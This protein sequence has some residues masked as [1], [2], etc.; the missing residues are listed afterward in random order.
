M[1]HIQTSNRIEYLI[2]ALATVINSEPLPPLTKEI[3]VVQSKGMERWV[4]MG[5]AEQL[6]V[7][8]NGDFPFPNKIVWQFFKK[9]LKSLDLSE[10]S[11]FDPEVMTWSLMEILPYFL[12][13]QEF[14]ELGSYLQED[15][16]DIKR[17]QLAWRIAHIFDQYVIFRP[18]WIAAWEKGEQPSE[19]EKDSQAR[20]QAILWR[21]LIERYGIEHRAKLRAAFFNKLSRATNNLRF[22]KRF[23]VFGLSAL[24]PFHLEVLA[25][26]GKVIDVYIFLLNPCME[27]WGDI[28]SDSEIAHRTAKLKE[29]KSTPDAQYYERGNTLLASMGKM[30][31]D[32]I[33][34]LNEYQHDSQDYF[35]DL[36]ETTL[37]NCIQSDILH[38][39]E[40]SEENATLI[41]PFDKSIQIHACHSPM[42]EIEV[43]HDQLLALFEEDTTLLPKDIVVMMPDI[44][45]YAP[46]IEAVFATTPEESKKIPY[47][48]ADR[49][50]RGESAV[51]DTFFAIL[52]LSH[53][54]FEVSQVL[55][56]LET[57]A[58]QKCFK[59]SEQDFDLI[60]H[61]IEK[62]GI[63]WG[64]DKTDRERMNLPAYD[65]NTWRAGLKRLLLGYTLPGNGEHLFNDILPYDEIEGSDTLILG[66]LVS[67]VEKLFEYVQALAQPRTLPEWSEFLKKMLEDFLESGDENNNAQEIRNVLNKLVEN[68]QQVGFEAPVS[69]EVILECLRHPLT[70][71]KEQKI[72]FLTGKVTFCAMLPMRSI[73]FKVVCLLGM[74]DQAYPRPSK[75]LG[76]DLLAKNPKPGDRSRRQND[77]Y[78]F[79]ESLL[80][81]RNY[82]YI[83]YVGQSIHDNTVMPPSVLVS[84]L[85]DY[86]S[87][88]FKYPQRDIL[89]YLIT[90]HP[91]QAFSPRYFNETDKHLFSFSNEYCTASTALLNDEQQESKD[92]IIEA[93]PIPQP[94]AEWKTLDINRLTRFFRNP[95]EFL[96]RE[97]LGIELQ[98]GEGLLEESEPFEILG[99]ERYNF[100]QTLVEKS[101]EGFDLQEYKAIAKA[102][103]QLPYGKIGD[104]VYSQ[105]TEQVQPFVERVQQA[106]T[107]QKKME[108][109]TINLTI[110]DM[111]ITGRLGRLWHNN[112]IHYRYA[113]IKAKD[114]IQLWIHHLI[115]NS[116]PHKDLPRH[117][118]LIGQNGGWAFKPVDNSHAILQELIAYYWQ[119]LIQPLSFFPES[120]LT[121]VEAMSNGKIEED[122]FYQAKSAWRGNDFTRGES[123]EEYYQLCFGSKEENTPLDNKQF[124]IV[125]KQFFEPL[126]EHRQSL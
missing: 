56:V 1:L 79:L 39:R 75:S 106:T 29:K 2:Q 33:D 28:V 81:A 48:I 93:L 42:R 120:S 112:L 44:E 105:L 52:E 67:F 21:A 61:W 14:T 83:S 17:F 24:P 122:A 125:A 103:G 89:E 54:R 22:P 77:R 13:E 72:N 4:S 53:S 71:E 102:G 124:K 43:L 70:T 38:L 7:F 91:L 26:L 104:Y 11:K 90:H 100:N 107:Q 40:G 50:L 59:L 20:W 94:E 98:A 69:Y 37:L 31:R 116:L 109:V 76:F 25:E 18:K 57:E 123:E 19:L 97:R 65:A 6:G 68:S 113:K 110:A 23:S 85:L 99:L 101:L 27:Y 8:A 16:Q 41:D 118:L 60:R 64:M 108:S 9:T 35:D 3:V 92:F 45:A 74:N 115:L 5:L 30:G 12:E 82:Y 84:E 111:R 66:K 47:S 49:S 51:I 117:S 96:L 36:T 80:S 78:L 86:I 95:T 119:G 58:V 55:A 32:F 15:D 88:G 87:K 126:L 63:R 34:M 114:F 73:P 62:T 46:F 10:I 121:F